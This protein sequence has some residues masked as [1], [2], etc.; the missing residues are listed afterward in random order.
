MIELA[1]DSTKNFAAISF[2][3]QTLNPISMEILQAATGM[4]D[5]ENTERTTAQRKKLLVDISDMRYS[6]ANVMS[7]I[8]LYL[9][10]GEKGVLENVDLFL[11]QT[12]N[13]VAKIRKYG[14]LL[15]FEQE[16]YINQIDE[17]IAKFI[18]SFDELV[19]IYTSDKARTDAYLIRQEIGPK[20]N[21][22]Q[23]DLQK[24]VERQQ[25]E[26]SDTG[27][28][29][30]QSVQSGTGF[31][32]GMLVIGLVVGALLLWALDRFTVTPLKKAVSAMEDVARGDGDLTKRLRDQ[33]DDEIAHLAKNFN[34]FIAK[35]QNLI[36]QSIGCTEQLASRVERLKVVSQAASSAA[37][38]Q[39]TNTEA[40]V[41][42]VTEMS[43]NV[44]EVANNTNTAAQAANHANKETANGLNVV[45][46]TMDV[47]NQMAQEVEHAADVIVKLSQHSEQ[48][49]AV[50][51]VI[52]GIA[53]QTNLLALNAAIEA[54]RAGEQGRGFAVVADEVRTLAARTQTSTQEIQEMIH[55]LQTGARE[56]ADA[57]EKGRVQ[58]RLGVEQAAQAGTSLQSIAEAVQSIHHMSEQIATSTDQQSKVVEDIN[59]NVVALHHIAETNAA[60]AQ[61]TFS[62]SNELAE[63]HRQLQ[64]LMAQF[65]IESATITKQV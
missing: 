2:A 60:G 10:L 26:I 38:E 47:I 17:N 45:Q 23:R 5:I 44:R 63:L 46:Q 19:T 8:R 55:N 58:A 37:D 64:G 42:A 4:L 52:K 61:Q 41:S 24:I 29:V 12:K 7:N 18:D 36:Q 65:K 6:W 39:Q 53:D 33:G 16:E 31:A 49:G 56:A 20:L 32:I 43:S 57:M 15:T 21:N 22:I 62:A 59:K 35:I 13:S 14:D 48:I 50:L 28:G 11:D 54:A 3:G 1:E 34:E 9:N 51:D 25:H 40:T 27:A 30:I